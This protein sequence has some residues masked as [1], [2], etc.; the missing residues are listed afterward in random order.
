M[1]RLGRN[2]TI[3]AHLA[4]CRSETDRNIWNVRI[5]ITAGQSALIFVR[6]VEI[7]RDSGKWRKSLRRKKLY[8]QR[9]KF[10]RGNQLGLLRGGSAMHCSDQ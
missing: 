10:Y 4:R 6:L 5:L 8:S 1:R 2:L 7:W 3:V 9:R